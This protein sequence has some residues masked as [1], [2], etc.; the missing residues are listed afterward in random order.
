MTEVRQQAIAGVTPPEVAEARIREVWPSVASFPGIAGVGRMLTNTI[1]LAPLAWLLM[2]VIYFGKLL[3]IFARRYT[4]TNRRVMVRKGWRGTPAG[5]VALGSIDDVQLET[6][7]NTQFFRAANVKI[8]SNG[9]VALTLP[10]VPDPESFR[11][12]ILNARNAW[13]PAKL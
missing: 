11:Q 8:L 6:D 3:P 4:L 13:V 9:T 12:A 2:S 10:G 5:E 1:V 7:A